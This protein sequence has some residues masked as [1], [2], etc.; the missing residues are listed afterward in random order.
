MAF[1]AMA[2]GAEAHSLTGEELIA[3]LAAPAARVATGVERVAISP[4]NDRVL[5]VEVGARW[6]ALA[7]E[8]RASSAT[9]WRAAWRHAVPGGVVAV[10]DAGTG[11]PV[12]RFAPGG[13]VAAV[14]AAR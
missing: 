9:G 6:Y 4:A 1:V 11:A 7:P 2:A 5:V 14:G 12:V 8:A 13:V 3:S 10:L